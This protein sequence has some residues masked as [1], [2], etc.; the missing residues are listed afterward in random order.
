MKF[1][2]T[3]ALAT[4]LLAGTV[5]AAPQPADVASRSRG[6]S[7]IVVGVVDEVQARFDRNEFG[8]QVIVTRAIVYV[9]ETL[10]GGGQQVVMVDVDGG[11]LNGLTL[12]VSDLPTLAQGKKAVF[13]LDAGKGGVH[14][15]HQRGR[16]LLELDE[17]DIAKD[18]KI[19]LSSVRSQVR[20]ASN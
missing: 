16:G 19:S 12:R 1:S 10:R 7:Q 9:T 15:L 4:C 8:D 17:K 3:L 11:T 20:S 5:T 2:A 18:L 13:F 14:R 6:A